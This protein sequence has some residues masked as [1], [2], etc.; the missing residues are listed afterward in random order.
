MYTVIT[1]QFGYRVKV[2]DES[3]G[4]GG[5]SGGGLMMLCRRSINR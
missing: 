2:D 1:C 5:S 4:G 3:S